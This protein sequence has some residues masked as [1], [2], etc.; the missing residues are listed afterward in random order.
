MIKPLK[1]IAVIS[2]G[3][4]LVG[5]CHAEHNESIELVAHANAILLESKALELESIEVLKRSN[6]LLGDIKKLRVEQRKVRGSDSEAS[7]TAMVNTLNEQRQDW[8]QHGRMLRQRSSALEQQAMALIKLGFTVSWSDKVHL[9]GPMKL[10]SSEHPVMAH[11]AQIRSVHPTMLGQMTDGADTDS[12]SGMSMKVP[13]LSGQNAPADLD[14]STFQRSRNLTF[15]AHAEPLT[16]PTADVPLNKIH[17]WRL[18]VSDAQGRPVTGAKINIDGHMPGHVHG[19][20]TQ[21]KITEELS[22]GE[23]L[24]DGVKFQMTG[25]WV[26]QF[27]IEHQANSDSLV[28]NLV[29]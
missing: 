4:S 23:Y 20:P 3:F 2:L 8:Q 10:A 1:F 12:K 7:F 21:P 16:Q 5:F 24:V 18:L 6:K 13:A 27:D 17:Q 25:W 29:L 14:V 15:F 19:L 9:H 22:P 11:N 26:M 28:F